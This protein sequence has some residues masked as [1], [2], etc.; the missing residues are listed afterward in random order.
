MIGATYHNW[1]LAE[2]KD[3]LYSAAGALIAR[4][5][6]GTA[7]THVGRELDGQATFTMTKQTQLGFGM[8]HIFPG[9]FLK[10]ATQGKSYTYPY[11]MLGYTF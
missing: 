5:I 10:N 2:A 3:G 7:G 6:A 11:V 9:E 4:S 1:W 8:G